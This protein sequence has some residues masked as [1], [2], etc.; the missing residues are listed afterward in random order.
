MFLKSIISRIH[1][2]FQ[3]K[4]FDVFLNNN[5]YYTMSY[6]LNTNY[7][8]IL[9]MKFD[10]ITTNDASIKTMI[11][12]LY[13]LMVLKYILEDSGDLSTTYKT[14]INMNETSEN[15]NNIYTV[16]LHT[17]LEIIKKDVVNKV[18]TNEYNSY[19]NTDSKEFND[20]FIS[21]ILD[22]LT[23]ELKNYDKLYNVVKPYNDEVVQQ[24]RAVR[25]EYEQWGL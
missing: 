4:L 13:K 22:E 2:K 20:Y 11:E 21:L 23:L 14:G 10:D 7:K 17:T 24:K 1:K 12:R 9:N 3:C 19:Y 8:K 5:D 15:I 18:M 25:C 6:V 16:T